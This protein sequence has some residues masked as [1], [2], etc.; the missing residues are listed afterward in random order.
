MKN[1]HLLRTENKKKY[2]V[3]AYT[4]IMYRYTQ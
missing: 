4:G 2:R 3:H 1:A